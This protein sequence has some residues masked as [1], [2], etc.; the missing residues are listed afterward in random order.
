MS[1]SAGYE[2]LGKL[3]ND[4]R[5]L[6]GFDTL[7]HELLQNSDDA[8]GATEMRIEVDDEG[9][10]VWNDGIFS[11]CGYPEQSECPRIPDETGVPVK[12]DFHSFRAISGQAKREKTNTTGAFGIGFTSVFQVTDNPELISGGRHWVLAYDQPESSRIHQCGGAC[13]RDHH[14][15]GTSFVLPWAR[16]PESTIRRR[17]NVP[18][19]TGDVVDLFT[20][21]A[22]RTLPD[23]MIFLRRIKRVGVSSG[24]NPVR[25]FERLEAAS[26]V[27]LTADAVTERYLVVRGDFDYE[28]D[29]LRLKHPVLGR[30]IRE[31][32]YEMAVPLC[33]P[34][35][36]LPLHAVLPT[37]EVTG[38]GLRLSASFFPFQNRKRVKFEAPGDPESEWNRAAVAAAA[39]GLSNALH[40]LRDTLSPQR[41]WSLLRSTLEV[42]ADE[43]LR[44]DGVFTEFWDELAEVLPDAE[45]V[46]TTRGEWARPGQAVSVPSFLKSHVDTL[47]GLGLRVVDWSIA[48]DAE[49][50]SGR[51]GL[52]TLDLA[53]LAEALRRKGLTHV[54]EF[55]RADAT[56]ADDGS[57][58]ALWKVIGSLHESSAGLSTRGERVETLDGCAVL[59]SRGLLCPPELVVK[60]D[61]ASVALLDGIPGLFFLDEQFGA[62]SNCNLGFLVGQLDAHDVVEALANMEPQ[63]M[64]G[65][66]RQTA[67]SELLQWL[68]KR[69]QQLDEEDIATLRSLPI[70]PT[71]SGCLPLAQLQL[72][73]SFDRDP[74][75]VARLVDLTGIG[76]VRGFLG[77]DCL[78]AEELTLDLYLERYVVPSLGRSGHEV[79]ASVLDEVLDILAANCRHLSEKPDLISAL[80]ECKLVPVISGHRVAGREAYFEDDAVRALLG[81]GMIVSLPAF[82]LNSLRSILEM[83]GVA[84]KPRSRDIVGLLQDITQGQSTKEAAAR[85]QSVVEYLGPFYQFG[86]IAE[87]DATQERLESDYPVLRQMSWLPAA[88]TDGWGAPGEL[89]RTDWRTAFER[90]GTFLAIPEKVQQRNAD[91]L[92]LLGVRLQPPPELVAKH[93]RL[94]V[95]AGQP[96][97]KR[98]YEA[99]DAPGAAQVVASLRDEPCILVGREPTLYARPAEVLKETRNLPGL[100]ELPSDLST[101]TNFLDAIGVADEPSAGHAISVLERLCGNRS[102]G[103]VP[104]PE[105]NLTYA[106]DLCWRIIEQERGELQEPG[107]DEE[108]AQLDEEISWRLGDI[109]CWHNKGGHLYPPAQLLVDD[110][111]AIA[112]LIPYDVSCFL[113]D[114]PRRSLSALKTAGLRN[115]SQAMDTELTF[116][117][118][119]AV[120]TGLAQLVVDRREQIARAL[121]IEYEDVEK[122]LEELEALELVTADQIRLQ[123]SLSHLGSPYLLKEQSVSAFLDRANG[124]LYLVRS[125]TPPWTE[126][127]VALASW[128]SSDG[129][130]AMLAPL[131]ERVL[132]A[133]TVGAASRAL[134]ELQI[135]RLSGKIMEAVRESRGGIDPFDDEEV[136]EWSGD[137]HA[138][139]DRPPWAEEDR[140]AGGDDEGAA[141]LSGEEDELPGARFDGNAGSE[142]AGLQIEADDSA[143]VPVAPRGDGESQGVEWAAAGSAGSGGMSSGGHGVAAAAFGAGAPGQH[144]V[145]HTEAEAP[146]RLW[147]SGPTGAKQES[148]SDH[149]VT[150]GLRKLVEEA[151]VR[152]VVRYEEEHGRCATVMPPNNPGFDVESSAGPHKP[153]KRRI[154]VKSL[155]GSWEAEWAQASRPPQ[156]TRQ[157]FQNSENDTLHWVYVVENALDDER[158][159]VYPIQTIGKRAN[160]FLLDHGWKAAADRSHGPG[161]RDAYFVRKPTL[162][163]LSRVLIPD[164][165]KE[166]GDVRFLTADQLGPFVLDGV[167]PQ[168]SRWFTSRQ[169]QVDDDY[170]ALQQEE[171]AMGPSLPLGSVAVFRRTRRLREDGNIVLANVS[172][173]GER[174]RLVIRRAFRK[175]GEDGEGLC[176]EVDVPGQG[177]PFDVDDKPGRILALLVELQEI[178]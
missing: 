32:R 140:T 50:L 53:I 76:E 63:S 20:S 160:R 44:P 70:F 131:F 66:M 98:V 25:A 37:Q 166:D 93:L 178:S 4:L 135:P 38:L 150:Q 167:L 111:P 113:A 65:L 136:T 75:G 10:V 73:G 82:R 9:I 101:Y 157:Q 134:D 35:T 78:G 159:V 3:G 154:E 26:V 16:D 89:Y 34:T 95:Q 96:V 128:L 77:S 45:V 13:G 59:P 39:D 21:D 27:S 81:P 124:R 5:D 18:P 49:P 100:H 142:G 155:G 30:D 122:P 103:D 88:N 156:L 162:P 114:R 56:L 47:V 139:D 102:A 169:P 48:R 116:V 28:A 68:A 149:Q 17:L 121:A 175:T 176:L 91:F 8:P 43:G 174:H 74:L 148:V 51:I 54:Q 112:S 6:L 161:L 138:A 33:E 67:A 72:P 11:D 19:V 107:L 177:E 170:F 108:L 133:P 172:Q 52:P 62:D 55:Q 127:A 36:V 132:T 7:V 80:A 60:S 173:D 104:A 164:D 137:D 171:A 22:L 158:W 24:G 58:K 118:N 146:W 40:R 119:Q 144:H 15:P 147:V 151:G 130:P 141:D 87:R 71:A 125:Q 163:S 85:V 69:T 115:L 152:R 90:A 126:I 1:L 2:F 23:A 105:E 106:L 117:P 83:F 86:T 29:S 46:W 120:D 94:C 97:V 64:A 123:R 129:L 31:P 110:M 79:T 109:P 14:Q 57:R 41:L 165:D 61:P 12:C 143:E 42:H 84:S 99:L 168:Q 92:E 145:V 153:V